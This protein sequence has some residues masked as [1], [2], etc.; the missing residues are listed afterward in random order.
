MSWTVF[1]LL[2]CSP[3]VGYA[4]DTNQQISEAATRLEKVLSSK[5]VSDS[6]AAGQCGDEVRAA[7]S[8]LKSGYLYLS[9]YRLRPC[10]LEL[11][12]RRYLKAKAGIEQKGLD[13]FEEE[14]RRLGL[15][16]NEREKVLALGQ[17]QQS[18]AL[19]L[20]LVE[21]SKIQI[22]PYYRSGRL[23]GLNT[24]IPDGLYYLGLAPANLDFALLCQ[25]LQLVRTT[26]LIRLRSLGPELVELETETIQSY[27]RNGARSLQPRYNLI[28][29]TLKMAS[30]LNREA[31]YAGALLRYLEA[32]LDLGLVTTP[33]L[34][35]KELSRLGAENKSFGRKLRAGTVD[36]SI[37]LLY[38][39]M[40]QGALDSA[41]TGKL[42]ENE[43][44]RAAVIVDRVLPLYFKYAA[45]VK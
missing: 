43:L 2:I 17:S 26:P 29:S 4:Q 19:I 34:E 25:Q 11:E 23:Y 10:L 5:D 45:E 18:V 7:R 3:A 6:L 39:E 35:E 13:A 33:K 14:W 40:A 16:L 22:R 41:A 27:K 21:A 44:Q 20:A 38:W 42:N 31:M 12:T 1:C 30:E 37:G 24:T 9:L 32:G 28:N 15:E 8:T 36:H